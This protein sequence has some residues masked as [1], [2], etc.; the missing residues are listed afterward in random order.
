M[1]PAAF[2]FSFSLLRDGFTSSCCQYPR[3]CLPCRLAVMEEQ[4]HLFLFG[5]QTV[6]FYASIRNVVIQSRN[7]PLLR[8]FLQEATDRVQVEAA[9][10]DADERTAFASFT[11]L[12]GLAEEY[13]AKEDNAVLVQTVLMCIARLGEL[14]M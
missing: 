8:S 3:F 2:I 6:D 5:D 7:S 10:L 11:N 1:Q 9:K 13:A 12:L 4:Q 14:I